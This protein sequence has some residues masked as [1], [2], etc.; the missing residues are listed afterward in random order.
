M[1]FDTLFDNLGY[2]AL[3]LALAIIGIAL[4]VGL[5]LKKVKPEKLKDFLKILA[6]VVIGYAVAVV[7][8]MTYI[9]MQDTDVEPLLFYPILATLITAIASGIALLIASI[10]GKKPMNITLI[11][12]GVLLLGCFIAVYSTPFSQSC[13]LIVSIPKTSVK[14][15][16]KLCL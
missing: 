2:V 3:Y 16:S 14:H 4:I 6:G 9:K 7:V 1:D 11:V 12:C 8:T 5:V 15:L 13:T 10:F